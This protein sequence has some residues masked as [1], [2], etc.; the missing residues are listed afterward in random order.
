MPPSLPPNVTDKPGSGVSANDA[1]IDLYMERA[2][3]LLRLEAGTRNS[4]VA[5]LDQLEK[6]IVGA[7]ASIDPTGV[8]RVSS[9][10]LRLAK[11]LDVVRAS[12]KTAYRKADAKLAS[13]IREVVDVEATWTANAMNAATHATFADAGI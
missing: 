2:V 9:Q 3:D 13:E 11:L 12:I 7:I 8:A 4:V 5:L 6:D 1:V 10:R